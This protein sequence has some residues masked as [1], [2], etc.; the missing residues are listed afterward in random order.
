MRQHCSMSN[1]AEAGRFTEAFA[2][3]ERLTI[4]KDVPVTGPA[5]APWSSA[6]IERFVD[7]GVATGQEG[8]IER[9][10]KDG[11]I[12]AINSG[13][14]VH[15]I[16][17][18]GYADRTVYGQLATRAAYLERTWAPAGRVQPIA[19]VRP[20]GDQSNVAPAYAA[21]GFT[22]HAAPGESG[23]P[24]SRPGGGGSGRNDPWNHPGPGE[25]ELLNQLW[26]QRDRQGWWLAEVPIGFRDHFT[27]RAARRIDAVVVAWPI[28]RHS[29]GGA[30]LDEFGEAIAGGASVEIIEAKRTLNADVTGQ[31]LCGEYQLATSWAGAGPRSRTVCVGRDGD[32]A[33]RWFCAQA[34]ISVEVVQPG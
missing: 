26:N 9:F 11:F 28:P 29:A 3:R 15:P 4:F 24:E 34:G 18:R 6:C 14:A 27:D 31:V 22:I 21:A 2:K 1:W 16:A 13:T 8:S 25:D 17:A 12:E 20:G 19:L 7:V 30:D 5:L 10:E 23:T 33:V 32:E